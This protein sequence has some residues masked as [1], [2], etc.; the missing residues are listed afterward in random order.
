MP[1]RVPK[2]GLHKGSGQAR[3]YLD[4]RSVY[5][6]EYASPDSHRRY[7]EVIKRWNFRRKSAHRPDLS[8][9]E[10]AILYADHAASYYRKNGQITSEV[11]CIKTALR[12]LVAKF[13]HDFVADFDTAKLIIVRD[14]MIRDKICRTSINKNVGRIV[15]MLRWGTVRKLVP[16]DIP[17]ALRELEPLRAGRC[18]GVVETIGVGPVEMKQVMAIKRHLTAPVWAMIQVQVLTGC[19]PGEVIEMRVQDIDR[20]LLPS[21]AGPAARPSSARAVRTPNAISQSPRRR[22][23]S[24]TRS[25]AV[26]CLWFLRHPL[27]AS[28]PSH[29]RSLAKQLPNS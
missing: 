2:Y 26:F 29:R 13:R 24:R 16:A 17:P 21:W 8:I 22:R 7:N 14:A 27:Q 3:V 19:R 9:G 28:N 4:G 18:E 6:G 11:S 12:Y 20:R 15:R 1:E 25:N 5:L 23:R 10:L